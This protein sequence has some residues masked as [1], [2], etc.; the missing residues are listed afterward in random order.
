MA[1][2]FSAFGL[3]LSVI[4]FVISL[5]GLRKKRNIKDFLLLIVSVGVVPICSYRLIEVIPLYPGGHSF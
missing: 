4:A 5:L 2:I 3:I 1:L